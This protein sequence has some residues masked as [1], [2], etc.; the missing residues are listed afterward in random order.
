RFPVEIS[1]SVF[2][3]HE[4]EYVLSLV[5][6]VTERKRKNA[7]MEEWNRELEARVLLRTSQLEAAN[8]DLESF[9][10]SISHDLRAPLRHIDGFARLLKSRLGALASE[11]AHYFERIVQA[12]ARM[13][14]MID[15]LL[16]FSR[17]G[18]SKLQHVAVDLDAM[19]ADI[20]STLKPDPGR[21]EVDWH[22]GLLGTVCGDPGL[23]RNVFENLLENAV[24]FSRR[25]AAPRIEVSRSE[26][27]GHARI[28]IRDNGVGFDP[29]YTHKLFEVFQ[30]LHDEDEFGGS[31]IGL[32]NVKRIVERHGGRVTAE[33]EQGKGA[34][35]TLILPLEEDEA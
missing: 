6:D 34:E 7:E 20:R 23:L 25:E 26:K 10:Y 11:E 29:E 14:R 1:S 22:I 21:P 30:R 35:F 17:I 13:H 4:K 15:D 33:G 16:E 32:A 9:A 31:G 19:V 2:R 12:S 8:R 28:R 5:R 18:R 3:F 27:D 24:K